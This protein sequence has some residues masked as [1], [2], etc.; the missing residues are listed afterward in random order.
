MIDHHGKTDLLIPRL[1]DALPP[2]ANTASPL[3][4]LL[5]ENRQK[6]QFQ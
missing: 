5:A 1:Q 2:E 3:A 6:F 4:K